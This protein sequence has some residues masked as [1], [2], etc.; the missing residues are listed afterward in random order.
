MC[1]PHL[2]EISIT[3]VKHKLI[4]RGESLFKRDRLA[5]PK[6]DPFF[7]SPC[8]MH[9]AQHGIAIVP[10]SETQRVVFTT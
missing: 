4:E 1:S 3:I 2:F 9:R 8:S 6:L 10:A 5:F 7:D